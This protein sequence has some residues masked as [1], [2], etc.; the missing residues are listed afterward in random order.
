MSR[1]PKLTETFILYEIIAMQEQG[2]EVALYPLWRERTSVMHPEA[3]PLVEHAHYQPTLSWPIIKANLHFLRRQ[4]SQYLG[5]V[6]TVLRHNWGSLRYFFG[7]L[8]ILPKSALFARQMTA[9]GIT[10]IHAHFASHPAAAAFFIK[11]LTGIPYSFTAHGS[12]IHR[13]K[14]MLRE[15]VEEAAFVVP[16]SNFNREVI[17]E[18]CQL[19]GTADE[20]LV[21]IHC[22]VDSRHFRPRLSQNG[23]QREN[24]HLDKQFEE[25]PL[26]LLCIGTLHEVKGQKYLVEACQLLHERGVPFSCRFVGDGPDEEALTNQTA[27]AGLADHIHFMGRKTR[28]E[29]IRL[30]HEAD[31]LVVPSVPSRDGR[32]EGIPV[33]LMEAMGC[34]LPVVASR[35]SG[36]PELVKDGHTGLLVPPGEASAL[37]GALTHLYHEAETRKRLGQA[38]RE[39]I[40]R[41]FDLH[42]NAAA[43]AQRFQMEV[44]Q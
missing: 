23:L 1:F 39:V 37:A 17:R 30:L 9:E 16:I 38:G 44:S 4:P 31:V 20:K 10:H 42:K 15:K 22:G 12:D 35:L 34:G 8:A 7:A 29:I 3:V 40:L 28:E 21:V 13:E 14:R 11:R 32:R 24:D 18:A 27:A 41:D 26:N 33:V 25:K 5:A 19:N 2:V 6:W 36:I 43:L